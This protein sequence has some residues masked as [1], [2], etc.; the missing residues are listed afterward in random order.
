MARS[1]YFST[2]ATHT[3]APDL[4]PFNWPD[5]SYALSP[6]DNE[7]KE[8]IEARSAILLDASTGEILLEK[9]A[10][11][12]IP[13]ASMTKLVAMYTAFKAASAGEITFDDVV[14]LPSESWA[15]NIPAGSSL[16]FLGA[17][18]RVTVRELLLGMAIA[19]G[20]DAA[21][22]LAI[23]VSG[24]VPAFVDRMNGEMSRLGLVHTHF[25][26]P[27]GLSEL[28]MTTAREFAD[29]AR[30]YVEEFPEALKAFHSKTKLEYPMSWNL[31]AG[32]RETPVV[33][34]ATN[35][36]LGQL[37]GCDGLKTGYIIESGY[38]LSL[39]AERNGTRFI[40]VTMGG[41]GSS[42]NTGSM[43][44]SKDGS[45]LI[46]WAF[47]NFT[48]VK[49][50]AIAPI[51]VTVWEG[52]AQGLEAIPAHSQYYTAPRQAGETKDGKNPESMKTPVIVIPKSLEAPVNAG[53]VIGRVE[54]RMNGVIV[55]TV[56]LIADRSVSKAGMVSGTLDRI[57]RG[58]ALLLH[59]ID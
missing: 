36:L 53:E 19:S 21:I 47:G 4:E 8:S 13:P 15:V 6:S 37:E 14:D 43:I 44:R 2:L 49:P 25:V 55:R 35:K 48:T 5:A 31:P 59:I 34:Y 42:S 3:D 10:D 29:F 22:A 50:E 32:S 51:D 1:A 40:S 46:E 39:T 38:N 9:D 11:E 56:P 26:E 58:F 30:V 12:L 17:G 20:N 54:Y 41:P 18:Q 52:S 16:M 24:S 23:H 28:N 57:T 7:V 27:S 33:Q 45:S